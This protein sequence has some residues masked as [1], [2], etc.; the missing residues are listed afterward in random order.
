MTSTG[1]GSSQERW[2]AVDEG[3]E[4]AIGVDPHSILPGA[5]QRLRSIATP[6]GRCMTS[7][8]PWWGLKKV[9]RCPRLRVVKQQVREVE[10][11]A[12]A[13]P[14]RQER[15]RRERQRGRERENSRAPREP[16]PLARDQRAEERRDDLE[17]ADRPGH[18]DRGEGERD[19]R[20]EEEE[21][22]EIASHQRQRGGRERSPRVH[23]RDVDIQPGQ[24]RRARRAV[25]GPADPEVVERRRQHA[26]VADELCH[27]ATCMRA[28]GSGGSASR[29]NRPTGW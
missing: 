9:E 4:R 22:A 24:E 15:P 26:Q 19:R 13:R 20:D 8:R 5:S 2:L 25:L 14:E 29:S 1:E 10:A 16:R 21:D 18:R 11:S 28:A 12:R 3:S 23:R 17:A 6:P 7:G 27:G